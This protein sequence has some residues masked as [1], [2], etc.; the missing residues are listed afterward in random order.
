MTTQLYSLIKEVSQTWS[1][2]E[3]ASKSNSA[4][5]DLKHKLAIEKLLQEAEKLE[6]GIESH[7]RAFRIKQMQNELSYLECELLLN[8]A[9]VDGIELKLYISVFESAGLLYKRR[10]CSYD[11]K[12]DYFAILNQIM[13]DVSKM[14]AKQSEKDK[15]IE[16]LTRPTAHK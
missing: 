5:S 1:D 7:P 16:K 12:K 6:C 9:Q 2:C 10:L 14:R 8:S 15:R 3:R 4:Y 11:C 13:S